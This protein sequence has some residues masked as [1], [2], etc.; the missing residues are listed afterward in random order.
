[1]RITTLHRRCDI[2]VFVVCSRAP[3][4]C[5]VPP[6]GCRA[7]TLPPRCR[8]GPIGPWARGP[9][10]R[11]ATDTARP[12]AQRE[13]RS[14][15]TG[16]T[17]A[18]YRS[19]IRGGAVLSCRDVAPSRCMS[20]QPHVRYARRSSATR[21]TTPVQTT[22]SI[23]QHDRPAPACPVRVASDSRSR[24]HPC[25]TPPITYASRGA[26]DLTAG[27][28]MRMLRRSG[29]HCAGSRDLADRVSDLQGR[30][31]G[32]RGTGDPAFTKRTCAPLRRCAAQLP[33]R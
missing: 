21:P 6:C 33:D 18:P 26:G 3:P 5:P 17:R 24:G 4:P 19:E 8:T 30:I 20:R 15:D 14:R 9:A 10:P 28:V 16:P 11:A 32:T 7:R 29:P 23:T 1:M 27:G 12:C 13:R 22:P 2:A 25:P 31:N